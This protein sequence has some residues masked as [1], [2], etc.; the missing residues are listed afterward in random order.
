MSDGHKLSFLPRNAKHKQDIKKHFSI[1]KQIR[2]LKELQQNTWE[3]NRHLE[4]IKLQK[5]VG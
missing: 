2:K 1:Y 4:I 5:L 3:Y